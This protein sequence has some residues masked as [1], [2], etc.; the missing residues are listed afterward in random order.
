[1]FCKRRRF[2]YLR[3]TCCRYSERERFPLAV[4][5]K[6]DAE[7]SKQADDARHGE[8]HNHEPNSIQFTESVDS[9]DANCSVADAVGHAEKRDASDEEGEKSEGLQSG[10]HLSVLAAR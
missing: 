6:E 3:D 9:I 1:M 5:V 10:F 7:R 4:P 8:S 2:D